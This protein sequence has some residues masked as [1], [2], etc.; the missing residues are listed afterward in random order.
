MK[1]DYQLFVEIA[2]FICCKELEDR[3]PL[4][5]ADFCSMEVDEDF[6]RGLIEDGVVIYVEKTMVFTLVCY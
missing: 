5:R 3:R 4:L 6:I 2:I 1:E